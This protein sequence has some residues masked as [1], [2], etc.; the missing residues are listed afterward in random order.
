MNQTLQELRATT[1]AAARKRAAQLA[2][3]YFERIMELL[4]QRMQLVASM[5]ESIASLE[6]TTGAGGA[7]HGL[8]ENGLHALYFA[9]FYELHQAGFNDVRMRWGV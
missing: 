4:R 9:I 1:Q 7:L 5:G 6:L 3:G 2:P 8:S